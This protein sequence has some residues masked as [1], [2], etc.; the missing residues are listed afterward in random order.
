M[1]GAAAPEQPIVVITAQKLVMIVVTYAFLPSRVLPSLVRA[2][3]WLAGRT[4]GMGSARGADVSTI[5]PVCF[6]SD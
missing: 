6:G 1:D 3:V 4:L 2:C 5:F